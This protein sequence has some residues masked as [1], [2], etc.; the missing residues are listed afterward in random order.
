MKKLSN[1]LVVIPNQVPP[2]IPTKKLPLTAY[3]HKGFDKVGPAGYNPR[4]EFVKT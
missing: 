4:S 2:S 1:G 3:T